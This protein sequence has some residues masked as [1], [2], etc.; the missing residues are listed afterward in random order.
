MKHLRWLIPVV[1]AAALVAVPSVRAGQA[2]TEQVPVGFWEST[3]TS[4]GGIGAALELRADGT[5][6]HGAVVLVETEYRLESGHPARLGM[7]DESGT[8][9]AIPITLAGD[10]MTMTGPDGSTLEKTRLRAPS[11]ASSPILGDWSYPHPTGSTAY[12]RYTEDG[13]M[14][15]RLPIRVETGTYEVDGDRLRMKVSGEK[16]RWTWR[17]EGDVL[18]AGPKGDT[19]RYRRVPDGTWY[20]PAQ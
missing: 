15:F 4:A 14:L 17:L 3:E 2:P 19:H 5:L 20:L 6:R 7:V 16:A 13:T 18:V 11:D 9:Q 8:E 12:E 10:T 1:L